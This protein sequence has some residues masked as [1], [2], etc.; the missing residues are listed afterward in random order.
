MLNHLPDNNAHIPASTLLYTMQ[1]HM[2]AEVPRKTPIA[3]TAMWIFVFNI[4]EKFPI[5]FIV[6]TESDA[7]GNT[8]IQFKKWYNVSFGNNNKERPQGQTRRYKINKQ[9][10]PSRKN[11]YPRHRQDTQH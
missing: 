8:F 1:K 9:T 7:L 11:S 2:N 5:H 10:G 4:F 6:I 3:L